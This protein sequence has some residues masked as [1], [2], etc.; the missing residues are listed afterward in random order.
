[1]RRSISIDDFRHW[2]ILQ[3]VC[4]KQNNP[5]NQDILNLIQGSRSSWERL[6]ERY[7]S[8]V[9]RFC[10]NFTRDTGTAEEWANETFLILK[11]KAGTFRPEAELRPWLY[12]IARNTCLQDLR[13]K[14]EFNWSESVAASGP[15]AFVDPNPS[16]ASRVE[17]REVSAQAKALLAQLSEEERT[18]V[19]L[20]FVEG[21]SRE[22]IAAAMDCPE[23]TVK[24]RLYRAM[25][26]LRTYLSPQ[27]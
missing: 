23:A 10:H 26:L 13:K 11:Q 7:W 15:L 9:L 25:K 14:R 24:S 22:E 6:Y 12:R 17:A 8:G 5:D 18:T 27:T 4:A 3:V 20:K 21:L 2:P 19:L 16:P 1:M